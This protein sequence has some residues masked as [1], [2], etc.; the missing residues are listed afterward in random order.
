MVE[1]H[2]GRLRVSAEVGGTPLW[3]EWDG[4]TPGDV[5]EALAGAVLMPAAASAR[6]LALD[7]AVSEVWLGNISRLMQIWRR[8]W[9]YPVLPPQAASHDENRSRVPATALCFTG[10]VDSFHSLL[11]GPRPPDVLAFVHGYD[12]RLDDRQRMTAWDTSFREVAEAVGAEAVLFRSNLREH[13]LSGSCSW[14]RAHGGALAAV[15]HL[16]ADRVGTLRI[17]SSW[18]RGNEH[19]WGSHW[20]TDPLWSS[21]R[22]EVE[23]HGEAF[24]R[25]QKMKGIVGHE[26][27][28]RHLRVCW[29]NLS[30]SG[31][32][33]R[34]D[35]CLNTM[36]FVAAFGDPQSFTSFDWTR[37][38]ER[39]LDGLEQTRFLAGYTNVLT[40]DL[41]R[42]LARAVRALLARSATASGS[43][44]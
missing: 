12:I 14:E 26:L 35:K 3:F 17:A 38:L 32:C 31:N 7:D 40:C 27:V 30:A 22:L 42:K 33:S 15:G 4:D 11:H 43:R 9:D 28:Q 13:P 1:T 37:P 21:D 39:R 19:R 25:L 41:D 23:H 36:T 8:W 44:G 24:S 10:G 18:P 16:L 2:G 29:E 5:A 20:E 6:R 34:C